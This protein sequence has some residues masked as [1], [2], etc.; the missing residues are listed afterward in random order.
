M[1][2]QVLI[3][4]ALAGVAAAGAWTYQTARYERQLSD[5]RATY[6]HAQQTA[7]EAANAN[8]QELLTAAT[9]R[10]RKAAIRATALDHDVD[11]VRAES[12]RLRNELATARRD[13]PTATCDSAR[14]Y[15][16]TAAHLLGAMEVEGGR[17]AQLADRHAIDSAR[18]GD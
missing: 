4:A 1:I 5:L 11:R 13:L 15:A 10:A 9:E 2:P 12:E 14:A 6:A 8:A 7:M 16:S 17:M 18:C 3:A